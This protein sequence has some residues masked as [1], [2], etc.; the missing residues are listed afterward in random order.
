MVSGFRLRRLEQPIHHLMIAKEAGDFASHCMEWSGL[1]KPRHTGGWGSIEQP[2]TS[3]RT[4]LESNHGVTGGS[5]GIEYLK[6][7]NLENGSKSYA[8]QEGNHSLKDYT[9]ST[10]GA[11]EALHDG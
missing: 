6:A 8:R 3:S 11:V 10:T 4:P 2:S 1:A 7:K 9:R 5:N